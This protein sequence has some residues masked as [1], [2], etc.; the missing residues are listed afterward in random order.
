MTLTVRAVVREVGHT[1]RLDLPA[2]TPRL[3]DA[4]GRKRKAYGVRLTYSL[5]ADVARVDIVIEYKDSAEHWPP[6]QPMPH[7]LNHLI[8]THRPTDVT[9]PDPQRRT[10]MGAWPID[11]SDRADEAAR[12]A[13]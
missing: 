10:G 1:V 7:W 9:K 8:D 5:R 11:P 2:A 12:T 4:T 6:Y 13:A 3:T